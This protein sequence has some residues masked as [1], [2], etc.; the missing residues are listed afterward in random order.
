M[1]IPADHDADSHAADEPA[2]L[3][4]ILALG[5]H[6]LALSDNAPSDAEPR[7][8]QFRRRVGR[9]LPGDL[10][11]VDDHGAVLR[12][13]T[14]TSEFGRGGARGRFQ[15]VAANVDTLLIVIAPAP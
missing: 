8:I 12:I 3:R 2:A 15:P 6:G 13:E 11:R 5:N 4:V 14:R 9:P 10:V 1:T 7:E